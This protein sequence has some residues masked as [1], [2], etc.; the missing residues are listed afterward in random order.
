MGISHDRLK[1]LVVEDDELIRQLIIHYFE[2]GPYEFFQAGDGQEALRIALNEKPDVIIT[3]LMM[4][5]LD[6]NGLIRTLRMMKDFATTPIIAVTAGSVDMRTRARQEG[7]N[8]VL[9]KPIREA[10][11]VRTVE[12]LL[13]LTPFVRKLEK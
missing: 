4:P 5:R 13:A 8:V 2:D 7:A 6:G 1:M 9:E 11:A 12:E 10:E 3:D